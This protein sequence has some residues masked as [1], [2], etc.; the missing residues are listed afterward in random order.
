MASEIFNNDVGRRN[1]RP[2]VTL[3]ALPI[4]ADDNTA[5]GGDPGTTYSLSFNAKDNVD[6]NAIAI[7]AHAFPSWAEPMSTSFQAS[8]FP[9]LAGTVDADVDAHIENELSYL[10][11]CVVK[12]NT[13]I[14]GC[15]VDLA[16]AFYY[17]REDG[18]IRNNASEFKQPDSCRGTLLDETKQFNFVTIKTDMKRVGQVWVRRPVFWKPKGSDGQTDKKTDRPTSRQAVDTDRDEQRQTRTVGQRQTYRQT[19]R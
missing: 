3:S 11:E 19:D 10:F 5:F 15:S 14:N 16:A 2:I 8:P 13:P 18:N 17:S 1:G 12:S 4:R 9:V 6:C 7:M